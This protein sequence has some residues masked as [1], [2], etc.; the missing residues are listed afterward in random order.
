MHPVVIEDEYTQINIVHCAICTEDVDV[1]G[2]LVSPCRHEFCERCAL[3]L[4]ASTGVW[5]DES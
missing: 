3:R 2:A 4:V 5:R 1:C